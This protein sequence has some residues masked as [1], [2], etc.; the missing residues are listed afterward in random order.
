MSLTPS[1][2]LPLQSAAPDFSLK[3]TDGKNVSL[4]DFKDKAALVVVFIC[5]HCP[6]V[7]FIDE[8]LVKFANDYADKSVGIVAINSND[9]E[10]YPLDS[11]E[12]MIEEKEKSGYPF[13]YLYDETQQVAKA[14]QA[15]CTPDF[16]VFDK[17]RKLRYRGQFDDSRPRTEVPAPVTGK[18]LRE[19]VDAVLA[20]NAP[21][22]TQKPSIGCNV[23][24]KPGNEP[25]W[26][27]T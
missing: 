27:N 10:K 18:D 20:G 2:M 19:A 15:A 5:N 7:K 21:S 24:W 13:L 11:F 23:K 22:S 1:R 16:Y 12:K 6:Y 4:S 26:L 3:S 14:Y 25:L 9:V 17:E 8:G